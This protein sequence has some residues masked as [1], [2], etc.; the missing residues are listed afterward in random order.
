MLVHNLMSFILCLGGMRATL[1][2]NQDRVYGVVRLE[3]REMKFSD[4]QCTFGIFCRLFSS[5]MNAGMKLFEMK[6][7][8]CESSHTT[9]VVS[10]G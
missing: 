3:G 6:F 5:V 9:Y 7:R 1:I 8:V 10:S 4:V 2:N